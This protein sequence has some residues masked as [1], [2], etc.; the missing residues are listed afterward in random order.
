[1]FNLA[2]AMNFISVA[3]ARAAALSQNFNGHNKFVPCAWRR[4]HRWLVPDISLNGD[5]ATCKSD[6]DVAMAKWQIGHINYR[7]LFYRFVC[8]AGVSLPAAA[9]KPPTNSFVVLNLGFLSSALILSPPF[10]VSLCLGL[11]VRGGVSVRSLKKGIEMRIWHCFPSRSS[12]ESSH[13]QA[14]LG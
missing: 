11:S 12:A 5:R 2:Y 14:G 13:P 10:A 7:N 6:W 9:P 3:A 1:M 8:I 4:R